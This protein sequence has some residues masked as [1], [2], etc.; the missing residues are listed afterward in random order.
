MRFLYILAEIFV[1]WLIL[2]LMGLG[3]LWLRGFDEIGQMIGL[4]FVVVALPVSIRLVTIGDRRSIWTGFY[5][6]IRPL[7][8]IIPAI[9]AFR[10]GST[11]PWYGTR[12]PFAFD[13]DGRTTSY[14]VIDQLSASLNRSGIRHSK[15]GG[16][17][18]DDNGTTWWVEPELGENRLTGWVESATSENRAQIINAIRAFLERELRLRVTDNSNG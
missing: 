10:G 15:A 3:L 7:A 11:L 13:F 8:L 2:V 17:L 14:D 1:L 5:R 6:P 9:T 16:I 18:C 4:C 12:R